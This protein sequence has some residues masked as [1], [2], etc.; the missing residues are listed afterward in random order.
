M[1]FRDNKPL[2]PA[3]LAG[4]KVGDTIG[5]SVS[6]GWHQHADAPRVIARTTPTQFVCGEGRNEL[7]IL[8]KDGSIVGH[9]FQ[10]IVPWTAARAQ[11]HRDRKDR[12]ELRDLIFRFKSGEAPMDQVRALLA[13]FSMMTPTTAI[14]VTK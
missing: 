1:S 8:R 10:D 3:W 6:V 11:E 7:R 14:V 9:R 4:L 5:V 2:D 13:V 12:E